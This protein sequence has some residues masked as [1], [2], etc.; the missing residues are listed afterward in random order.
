MPIMHREYLESV[1]KFREPAKVDGKN[2]VG[3]RIMELLLME[4]GSDPLHPDMGVGIRNYRYGINV[5][6]DMENRIHNQINTYLPMYA[7]SN[8]AIIRTP[9]KMC[10]IEIEINGDF[11]VVYDSAT[12]PVPISL[13]DIAD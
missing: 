10:R 12:A 2:A 13:D 9:D 3:L 4:P 5:L 8:I 11:M 7:V 1:N 6:D